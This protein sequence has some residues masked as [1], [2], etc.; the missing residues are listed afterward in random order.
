MK[1]RLRWK[2]DAA[3]T[4]LASIGAG[5]RGSEYHDGEQ[6]YAS[7]CPLGGGLRLFRGWFWV[8]GWG[9]CVPY[10]NTCDAPVATE[11]EAKEQAEAYV[12]K[13]LSEAP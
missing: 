5:P 8:T 9:S 13:H 11:Q 4:G 10:V 2:K 7:V 3:K 1:K 6:K 12:K